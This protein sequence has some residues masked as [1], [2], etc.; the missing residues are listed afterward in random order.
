MKHLYRNIVIYG[1]MFGLLLLVCIYLY[2]PTVS[3][4]V[5]RGLS[6]L[7][8][9]DVKGLTMQLSSLG[10]QAALLS[11]VLNVL[12]ILYAPLPFATVLTATITIVGPIAG[13]FVSWLGV[14]L[15]AV[16]AYGIARG[17]I[18]TIMKKKL[19]AW[20]GDK[21]VQSYGVLLLI[22]AW[23]IPGWPAEL[24]AYLAGLSCLN[25]K[26]FIS[27]TAIAIIPKLWLAA[28]WGEIIPSPFTYALYL[29]SLLCM[30]T[31]VILANKRKMVQ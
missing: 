31:I 18:G 12:Q 30:I 15:G 13:L 29:I 2:T 7:S 23:L 20:Q 11:I 1:T 28:C 16:A 27:T 5:N 4:Q 26:S 19:V 3:I 10:N 24:I 22:A 9:H 8:L 17:L 14:L 6:M 21:S 25:F